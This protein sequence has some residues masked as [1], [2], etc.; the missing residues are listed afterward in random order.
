MTATKARVFKQ[1]ATV[2]HSQIV[3]S[4]GQCRSCGKRTDLQCAHIVSRRY[5]A[6]RT[7]LDNAFCLCAGCHMRYTEWPLEFATFVENEIGELAYEK[8]RAKALEGTRVDW[9]A[10]VERLK[11]LYAAVSK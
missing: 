1:R 3:R 4:A 8:L 10:E 6:T 2:L 9:Q 5:S 7:D 11:P